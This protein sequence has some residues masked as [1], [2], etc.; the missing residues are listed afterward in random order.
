M[1][2]YKK[3]DFGRQERHNFYP[4]PKLQMKVENFGGLLEGIGP[5]EGELSLLSVFRKFISKQLI[6]T[7]KNY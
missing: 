3:E 1:K 6:P 4:K 2:M 7:P 5:T